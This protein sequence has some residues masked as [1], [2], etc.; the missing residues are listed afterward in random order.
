M[1]KEAINNTELKEKRGLILLLIIIMSIFLNHQKPILG[2][3]L[4]VS[5]FLIVVLFLIFVFNNKLIIPKN[6]L[7]F[8]LLLSVSSLNTSL[9]VSPYKFNYDLKIN[10]I[11]I[12]Y[13]KL[14]SSFLYYVLGYNLARQKKVSSIY[15]WYSIGAIAIGILG[16]LIVLLNIN[17]FRGF[18][19]YQGVRYI[20]LMN[21]PNFFAL[22]QC[23]ALVYVIKNRDYNKITQILLSIVI[24]VSIVISGSKT[25]IIII[26][27]YL[28]ISYVRMFLK[29]NTKESLIKKL[30]VLIV[31]L[32]LVPVLLSA[33]EI[34]LEKLISI[35]PSL[36][37]IRVLFN[38]F[39]SAISVGGSSRD[40][41]WS[42]AID[43]IIQS[44]LVGVGTG[45]YLSVRMA[46]GGGGFAHN[47]FLQIIAEWGIPF[48][49]IMFT[50]MAYVFYK[51]RNF[52]NQQHS[53][54]VRDILL[55]LL[56]G[57][58]SLSINNARMLW[59]FFGVLCSDY[60]K[61]YRNKSQ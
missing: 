59:L 49:S 25:G 35:N 54:I 17:V 3:N 4:S 26:V 32:V 29:N 31:I 56:I 36:G 16:I 52:Y 47:T 33:M 48:A 6:A 8:F 13:I 19:F 53:M 1:I 24:F 30:L 18:L 39:D 11:V 55:I 43:T 44:P 20:G 60:N 41:A 40:R 23:T 61:F 38:D 51:T 7:F 57:S 34:A 12:D 27:L 5:D 46:R 9:F 45:S 58:L 2:F 10:P 37:R 15:K 42:G 50:Y 21:D 22:I 14:T 28:T